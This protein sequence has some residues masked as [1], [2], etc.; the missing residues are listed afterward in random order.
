MFASYMIVSYFGLILGQGAISIFPELGL[1]PLLLIAICFSLCIVPISLTRRLHPAPLVP[2][3]LKIA[4]YWK[5]APQALTTIAI[6][7]MIVGSFYGLAP[8]YA[9]NLGLPPEKVATY[10]TATILAG[11]L[12][13]WPMGKLSDIMSRSRLIRINCILLGIL[14]LAIA[15]T[16]Y[17]PVISLVM[18]FLFGILGFTFYPL[19]TALANSRVEQ[20]ERVGLS[21]TI[22]LTF[23]LGA[24]IGP[25]IASTLMQWLGNSM[26]YGFMSACTLILFVRLR[27]VHAQQKAE[28][29]VTQ[30]YIMAT[31]DL[32]SS[33]LA[34][35]LDPRVDVES[36]Q[37]HMTPS[38]NLDES[39][40]D[41]GADGIDDDIIDAND[42]DEEQLAFSFD[43]EQAEPE[44]V[45]TDEADSHQVNLDKA[46]T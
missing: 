25:L 35:A 41:L 2:A 24:S 9:S 19:A 1:E 20:N 28:T 45:L 22:L 32:V 36:I 26:L 27:Y 6:G 40:H 16:P 10:M 29:N 38:A 15:L 21:A 43:I 8:A 11:L 17:H 37:E 34:A 33:P 30:D 46:L 3:P 44:A 5:K 31:G 42:S 18:T 14:A 23:G 7:S 4:H 13:Q 12:A 39:E